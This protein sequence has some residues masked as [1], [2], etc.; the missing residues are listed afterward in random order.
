MAEKEGKAADVYR[1]QNELDVLKEQVAVLQRHIL[2]T[3]RVHDAMNS[4]ARVFGEY[5]G[6][7][8]RRVPALITAVFPRAGTCDIF[9]FDNSYSG[10]RYELTG[11][12]LGTERGQIMPY[13]TDEEEGAPEDAGLMAAQ[14]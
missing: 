13:L 8:N 4:L 6:T 3:K 9:V 5:R 12:E 2:N 10:G 11:I 7:D 1:L 14:R